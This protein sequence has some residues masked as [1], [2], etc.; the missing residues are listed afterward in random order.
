MAT[1][2][3]RALLLTHMQVPRRSSDQLSAVLKQKVGENIGYITDSQLL[4][5]WSGGGN[6][7][8][9]TCR[10][11]ASWYA[12][13][14]AL[15]RLS[16]ALSPR[17]PWPL[18]RTMV[19]L[20]SLT[21]MTGAELSDHEVTTLV[22]WMTDRKQLVQMTYLFRKVCERSTEGEKQIALALSLNNEAAARQLLCAG[23]IIEAR[24]AA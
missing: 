23:G 12:A 10:H 14:K 9:R 1:T 6:M 7:L 15:D 22:A 16:V 11:Y 17:A 13:L 3:E 2:Y 24:A 20:W 18:C 21:G 19:Y 8:W 4:A 5:I